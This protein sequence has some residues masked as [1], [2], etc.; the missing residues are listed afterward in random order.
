MIE[1]DVDEEVVEE[2]EKEFARVMFIITRSSNIMIQSSRFRFKPILQIV[3]RSFSQL[4][5]CLS[6][7]AINLHVSYHLAPRLGHSRA[8]NDAERRLFTKDH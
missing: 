2:E 3:P 6:C 1:D 7:L 4:S 5:L 8:A